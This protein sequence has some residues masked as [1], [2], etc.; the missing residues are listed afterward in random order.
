MSIEKYYFYK[1]FYVFLPILS[2]Q[3]FLRSASRTQISGGISYI[4]KPEPLSILHM[5]SDN[6]NSGFLF[7]YLCCYIVSYMLSILFYLRTRCLGRPFTNNGC[8]SPM[9]SGLAYFS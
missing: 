9:M 8:S 4:K 3:T 5:Q 6:S 7:I 1:R 2:I